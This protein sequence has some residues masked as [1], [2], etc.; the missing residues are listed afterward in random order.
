MRW[1]WSRNTPL[2][3]VWTA[4]F[5]SRLNNHQDNN[6]LHFAKG[7]A[8]FYEIYADYEALEFLVSYPRALGLPADLF[9]GLMDAKAHCEIINSNEKKP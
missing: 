7:A 4:Q 3:L 9:G 5:A 8:G 6:L 1:P 2:K